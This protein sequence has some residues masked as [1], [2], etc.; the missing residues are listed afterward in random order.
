MKKIIRRLI[1]GIFVIL[2]V[3]FTG[4]YFYIH[5]YGKPLLQKAFGAA[6]KKDVMFGRLDYRF[7]FGIYAKNIHV[8]DFLDA[9]A[10]AAQLQW[11]SVFSGKINFARIVLEKPVIKIQKKIKNQEAAAVEVIIEPPSNKQNSK[12]PDSIE[13]SSGRF[14]AGKERLNKEISQ[15]R[16]PA[17]K[18][19]VTIGRLI[20]EHGRIE[21]T[22]EVPAES[23]DSSLIVLEDVWLK[24]DDLCF[25]SQSKPVTFDAQGR[26][27]SNQL[28]VPAGKFL[29]S[30]WFNWVKKDMNGR[31]KLMDEKGGVNL[32]AKLA[33]VNNQMKVEGNVRLESASWPGAKDNKVL[34]GALSAVGLK[35][36]VQF[37]FE[38][39]MDDFQMNDVSF[40][41]NLATKSAV[42]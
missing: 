38:T 9:E 34:W 24:A 23:G 7:P 17:R 36:A 18:I 37:S 3:F 39:K 28:P 35:I 4:S 15:R 25:P 26:L 8:E 22:R 40:A 12:S 29:F 13:K 30:G 1:I 11:N 27:L 31:L 16:P 2:A 14:G 33:S 21:L 19:K 6:F 41:G 5:Y 32:T 42:P 10:L 20:F